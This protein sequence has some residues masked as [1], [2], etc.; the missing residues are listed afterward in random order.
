MSIVSSVI[1]EDRAQIDGRRSVRERHTDHLGLV[2]DV[3]YLAVAQADVSAAMAARVQRLEQQAA[4]VEMARNIA[5]IM[6]G[7][8]GLVT[9]NYITVTD[10]R[11]AIR[12]LYQTGSGEIIGRLAGYLLTLTNAQLQALFNVTAGAQ[13]TQLRQRLQSKV[14]ALNAVLTAVGE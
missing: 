1:A 8:Y 6:A 14:D 4:E 3:S 13:T 5:F 11:A 7:E 2:E 10:A 12:A 9:T